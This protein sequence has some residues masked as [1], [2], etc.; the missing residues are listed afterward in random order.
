MVPPTGIEP[1]FAAY[2]FAIG[3]SY[4][5]PAGNLEDVIVDQEGQNVVQIQG[6][7]PTTVLV[8]VAGDMEIVLSEDDRITVA[9][10]ASA[11]I[12]YEFVGGPTFTTAELIGTFSDG[13][14]TVVGQ[15][16]SFSMWG[17]RPNDAIVSSQGHATL[18]GGM[19]NDTL[20]GNGGNNTYLY[21]PGDGSD[22][23]RELSAKVDAQ[24]VAA[25]NRIKFGAGITPADL[26][27]TGAAGALTIHVG[28]FPDDRIT[29]DGYDQGNPL[30]PPPIDLLEFDD[31]SILTWAEFIARG[32]DGGEDDDVIS[33]TAGNDRAAGGE[34]QDSM[35]GLKG[36]DTLDGGGGND[37][38]V[39]VRGTISTSLPPARATTSW[40]APTPASARSTPSGSSISRRRM[41]R[42]APQATTSC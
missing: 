42:S 36:N 26:R 4:R 19:G 37:S 16:A 3:E 12:T 18:A 2:A 10:G 20:T 39:A 21:K 41:Y 23:L 30:A 31:D 27:L 15:G 7:G 13:P 38:L 11:P 6:G 33:G 1:V 35:F 40:T 34:G 22:L 8:T 29:L 32:F 14:V 24:G 9:S 28:A 25:P 17:G 5:D